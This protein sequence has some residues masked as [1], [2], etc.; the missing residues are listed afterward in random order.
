MSSGVS[1][2]TLVRSSTRTRS[3]VRSRQSSWPYPTSTATTSAAP[4][5][6]STSV[7][8]PVDAPA[9]RQ[10]R[11]GHG[12]AGR[13]PGR[14]PACARRG[15]PSRRSP[16]VAHG[17]GRVA[18]DDGGRLAGRPPDRHPARSIS[19]AAC[20]RDRARPR[21]TSSASR[22]ARATTASRGRT[23]QPSGVAQHG[24][25]VARRPACSATGGRRVRPAGQRSPHVARAG[26]A[27]APGQGPRRGKG[28]RFLPVRV[29][30]RRPPAP[31][32]RQP[33]ARP[34]ARRAGGPVP[35]GG[36]PGGPAAR[37]PVRGRTTRAGRRAD[38]R[39]RR[40]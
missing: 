6:S 19:S 36:D 37:G 18:V 40:A 2:R 20:S 13:R 38:R 30:A 23:G 21:R 5:R 25:Q 22:R 28:H 39:R 29:S 33:L 32:C 24:V 27:R 17:D 15:T 10:R 31:R 26:S 8:P 3:S 35:V 16:I 7:N 34:R 4:R 12:D 9:S 14:R 1:A 11:P